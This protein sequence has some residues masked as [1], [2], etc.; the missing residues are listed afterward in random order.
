MAPKAKDI[1]GRRASDADV[2][3]MRKSQARAAIA[4]INRKLERYQT[5]LDRDEY[6]SFLRFAKDDVIGSLIVAPVSKA[7]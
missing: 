5:T 6:R 3:A 7:S 1:D 2:L 4:R